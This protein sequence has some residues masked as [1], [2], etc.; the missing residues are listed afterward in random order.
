[1]LMLMRMLRPLLIDIFMIMLPMQR[2][3]QKREGDV[4]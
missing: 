1:M 4:Y 2:I 3:G